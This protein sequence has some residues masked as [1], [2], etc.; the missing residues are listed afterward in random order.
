MRTGPC[1]HSSFL[2]IAPPSAQS[3]EICTPFLPAEPQ[4]RGQE[5][6]WKL[7]FRQENLQDALPGEQLHPCQ[8]HGTDVTRA[9]PSP[10]LVQEPGNSRG[11]VAPPGGTWSFPWW[12]RALR[13][14]QLGLSLEPALSR[15]LD[16]LAHSTF[17]VLQRGARAREVHSVILLGPFHLCD[18]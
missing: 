15:E 11:V 16:P 13:E 6:L 4:C 9:A 17:P 12:A 10:L 8:P 14:G 5:R 7:Q 2:L 3:G 1:E 18:A